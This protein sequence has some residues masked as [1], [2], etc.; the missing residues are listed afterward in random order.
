[1]ASGFWP[2]RERQSSSVDKVIRLLAIYFPMGILIFF[3]TSA[4][5]AAGNSDQ[6]GN[7]TILVVTAVSGAIAAIINAWANREKADKQML[8]SV[9]ATQASVFDLLQKQ[10]DT[11]QKDRDFYR[12]EVER[13]QKEL[14]ER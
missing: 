5:Y 9:R 14:R 7:Q 4:A 1:M 2:E 3:S 12:E 10:I 13:L 6:N 11:L 8:D